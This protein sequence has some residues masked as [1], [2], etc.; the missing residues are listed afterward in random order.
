MKL[1]SSFVLGYATVT[2]HMVKQQSPPLL[3]TQH[4]IIC[5]DKSLKLVNN[6]TLDSLLSME[7]KYLLCKRKATVK[8]GISK[9]ST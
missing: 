6:I 2:Y 4:M 5:K 8:L 1:V 3:A 7:Y 9:A